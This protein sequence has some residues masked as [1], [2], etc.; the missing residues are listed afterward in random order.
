VQTPNPQVHAAGPQDYK[1][2]HAVKNGELHVVK[3][4][5]LYE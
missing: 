1:V 5:E 4:G 3:N 2:T